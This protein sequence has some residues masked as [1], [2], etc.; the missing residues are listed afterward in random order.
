MHNH[1]D[2]FKWEKTRCYSHWKCWREW[3]TVAKRAYDAAA[4]WALRASEATAFFVSTRPQ[5]SL[6]NANVI[7]GDAAEAAPYSLCLCNYVGHNL[8]IFQILLPSYVT[9]LSI[10]C[11]LL[12]R[13][14][15]HVGINTVHNYKYEFK[16]FVLVNLKLVIGP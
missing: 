8:V 2:L 5:S 6:Q 10:E 9:Q 1:D 4:Q 11:R 16:L 3:W 13:W 12:Q 14:T 15:K 7:C